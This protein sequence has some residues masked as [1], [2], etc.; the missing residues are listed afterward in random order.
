MSLKY[1]TDSCHKV[2]FHKMGWI[3][4]LC[5]LTL[6]PRPTYGQ[7]LGLPPYQY[8]SPQ[9]YQAASR[10]W[11]IVTDSTGVVYAANEDGVL[12]YDGIRWE[13]IELPFQ[14]KAYWVEIDEEDI[15]YVG[16]NGD[17]G[18][19]V[20]D[21]VGKI[22]YQSLAKDLPEAFMDFN[23][24]WEV[25]STRYGVVFRSRNYLFRY[26]GGELEVFSVPEK[27]R[28]FDAAY[29]DRGMAYFRIY[30]LG[31]GYLDEEGIKVLPNSSFFAERK[32]N[33]IYGYGKDKLLIA[34][35]FEGL[36]L[37]DERE[38]V[39]F[40]SEVDEYLIENKIYDGHHLADGNY[41]LATMASGLVII[42][43]E[44]KEV[45]RFDS[46]NGLGNNATLFVTESNGHLWLATKNG[47][48]KMAHE[49]PYRLVGK[50]FGLRGQVSDIFEWSGEQ[51]V[52]CNDGFYRLDKDS[53]TPIFQSVNENTIIDCVNLFDH[54]NTL[55]VTSLEGVYQYSK[56]ELTRLSRFSG[57]EV[58]P[59]NIKNTYLASEFYFGLYLVTIEDETLSETRVEGINRMI[60]QIVRMENDRFWIRSIDDVLYQIVVSEATDGNAVARIEQ[61][62]P[63]SPDTY[64]LKKGAEILLLSGDQLF[65]IVDGK[66]TNTNHQ[67]S[68]QYQPQKIVFAASLIT[69]T[70]LICYE[71][72]QSSTFC[73]KFNFDQSG[74][75]E[76]AGTYMY[77][78]FRPNTLFYDV[79]RNEIW[80]GGA[81]G[82][83]IFFDQ[84]PAS[85]QESAILIRQ[86]MVNDSAISLKPGVLH[87]LSHQENN[88]EISFTSNSGLS[89]GKSLFQYRLL[90]GNEDW[91]NWS[92]E[93]K[94][95]YTDLSPSNYEFQVRT[96][97]PYSGLSDIS[98][99]VFKILDPWYKN[100]FAYLF[101]FFMTIIMVYVA[102]RIRVAALVN[103]QRLLSK[104][105]EEKTG[106]LARANSDLKDKAEK[107]ERLS[108]FK[109]RF[110]SN[111][112]HDLRT[113]IALLSGRIQLLSEDGGSQLSDQASLYL[114]RIETDTSKIL[115][116]VND[117]QELVQMEEGQLSM[118]F[119]TLEVDPYFKSISS[120]FE[121][122]CHEKGIELRLNSSI[123]AG[124]EVE[125]DPHYFERVVFNLI[126]NAQK[127]TRSGGLIEVILKETVQYLIIEINDTGVGIPS[128]EID[129]I[130]NRS[131]QAN[132]Q[133]KHDQ[134]LGIG[135][136][137]VR[138]LVHMH[139]GKIQVQSEEGVGSSF[140][141]SIPWNQE[142]EDQ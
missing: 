87:E 142:A 17:F 130:F 45:M 126:S 2:A 51:Y 42:T 117:I 67:M 139:R 82:I 84:E 95:I 18:M 35:R 115:G 36:F 70:C 83:S 7:E 31:L 47:I 23:V 15:I 104:S 16:A 127:F 111:V 38:I 9:D 73:E 24:V 8:Y 89:E 88:I 52:A 55:H 114:Q 65:Q 122:S 62:L 92:D 60:T 26:F 123:E 39:P 103:N 118:N 132:N 28:I 29:T 85:E 40:R 119:Q 106:E 135:L 30:D 80:L 64:I 77:V 5:L 120:L 90:G 116:L 50:E 68:F 108:E 11:S 98:I 74:N 72:A 107:L 133:L 140:S 59:T 131:F 19:L 12:R 91:S 25:V 109:S 49:A 125:L 44:G 137:V 71:D 57:R 86:M 58:I 22:V 20:S 13:L 46:S 3:F 121:S 61:E 43:P 32:V 129:E 53:R 101:Y 54:D 33:G 34:T 21:S 37:Y 113:P 100:T 141:V 136:N 41:A 14:Q 112:S 27:G 78:G 66:L 138:E 81:D 6:V 94:V 79:A 105:V 102:Y 76:T 10:N 93:L 1:L 110:L 4:L 134:G 48:I 56:A 99:L 97:S 128:S 96:K 63:L 75:L 124:V 69:D